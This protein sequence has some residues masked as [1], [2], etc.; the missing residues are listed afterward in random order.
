MSA[1]E[2]VAISAQEAEVRERHCSVRSNEP[3]DPADAQ[4]SEKKG[5]AAPTLLKAPRTPYRCMSTNELGRKKRRERAAQAG[6]AGKGKAPLVKRQKSGL[7]LGQSND[8]EG[9]GMPDFDVYPE[10]LREGPWSPAAYVFLSGIFG[11]IAW[12]SSDAFQERNNI[13]VPE[14][15]WETRVLL[16]ALAC[17]A[18]GVQ[19]RMCVQ[20]GPWP[21]VSYTMVSY[22]LLTVRL[23][24]VALGMG[25]VAEFLRF[26]MLVMAT[27][28]TTVWW[29]L[30]VPAMLV[31]MPE[32]QRRKFIEF[33]FSFF[34]ISV[35]L[36]NLPLAMIDHHL[37]WR[38]LSLWDLWVG[39]VVAMMYL[40]FYLLVLDAKGMHFY[41]ILSPRRAWCCIPGYSAVLLV[42]VGIYCMMG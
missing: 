32:K 27:N 15:S 5:G 8:D 39:L 16:G 6:E 24:S 35:H 2:T 18:I 41:I 23:L 31:C 40:T 21:Y 13:S 36:L 12:S 19:V 37:T 3:G 14:T 33:N 38:P 7:H 11:W 1:N 42:Y 25:A 20:L 34:L 26:P 28:T 29:T 17:Y 10:C 22:A 30:I 4:A 9:G